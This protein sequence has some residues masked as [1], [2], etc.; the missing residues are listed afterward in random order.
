MAPGRQA[1]PAGPEWPDGLG[2]L[3]RDIEGFVHTLHRPV[4][5]ENGAELFDLTVSEWRLSIEHGR[6]IF[7]AWDSHRSLARRVE[8]LA[9]R[10]SGH[11]LGRISLAARRQNGCLATRLEIRE[12]GWVDAGHRAPGRAERREFSRQLAEM[13]RREYP[14][15]KIERVSH[16]SDREHSLSAWYARGQ[17]RRG[18]VL[19]AFLGLSEAEGVGARDSALAFGL[20]WL[21]W[22]GRRAA[23]VHIM[24]L[25][26]FLP[27]S[28]IEIAAHRAAYLDR[29]AVA[30]EILERTPSNSSRAAL[31][32]PP[33]EPEA[34]TLPEA[35]K[36]VDLA[37]YGNVETGL[38]PRRERE[39]VVGRHRELVRRL[40]GDLESRVDVVPD[41]AAR[42]LSLRVLGLEVARV[43]GGAEPRVH[44]GSEGGNVLEL[45]EGNRLQFGDFLKRVI[46]VRRS[47]GGDPTHEFYRLQGERWLESLLLRDLTRIDPALS[48][49]H[50]YSQVPA[51]SGGVSSALYRGVIDVLAVRQSERSGVPNRLAVIEL[52]LYEEINLPLQGLDYWLRVKWLGERGQFK[53]FGYFPGIELS[54]E[55]P[56]LYL[57]SPAFRFHSTT[58]RM[59]DYLAPEV[60]VVQ[61]GINQ[62]WRSGIKVLFRR[63]LED[64]EGQASAALL[65]SLRPERYHGIDPG[66]GAGRDIGGERG[67]R[68]R[69]YD[70]CDEG[71]GIVGGDAEEQAGEQF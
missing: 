18:D 36:V 32:T 35:P 24:G 53:Q 71:Q 6:L 26:L 64:G 21:D 70:H 62:S 54:P 41:A 56:L 16:R 39:A 59:V 20:V 25:K 46:E 55:P 31:A 65:R 52:K 57:V 4:L 69:Q 45:D 19:W 33:S 51:L 40:L 22:L 29:R 30:V 3:R 14:G 47:P 67:D 48:P 43:A 49:D 2:A 68:S 23:G 5:V 9:G 28:A 66:R 63:K 17:A 58:H 50:V 44:F 37:D 10:D 8:G 38:V 60:E 11:D 7:E 61:V 15:W 42:G 13:L 1:E 34:P 27:A 12:R